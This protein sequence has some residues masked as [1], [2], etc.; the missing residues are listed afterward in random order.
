MK[1]KTIFWIL[2]SN[3]FECKLTDSRL[4]ENGALD[5]ISKQLLITICWVQGISKDLHSYGGKVTFDILSYIAV[6]HWLTH[7]ETIGEKKCNSQN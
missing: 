3:I 5:P 1:Q 4:E 2:K 6:A 7:S